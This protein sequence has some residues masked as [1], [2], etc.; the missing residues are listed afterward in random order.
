MT[1]TIHQLLP[2]VRAVR[3]MQCSM[4]YDT[5]MSIY[6]NKSCDAVACVVSSTLT[7][8]VP[9]QVRHPRVLLVLAPRDRETPIG[10]FV[11]RAEFLPSLGWWDVQDELMISVSPTIK[12]GIDVRMEPAKKGLRD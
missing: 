9:I 2:S 6:N 4:P 11:P 3:A 5:S 8:A 10:L 1:H 12:S 7:S